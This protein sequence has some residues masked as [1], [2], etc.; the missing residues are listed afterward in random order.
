MQIL[1]A[2]LYE[3]NNRSPPTMPGWENQKT[4]EWSSG[5]RVAK[6]LLSWPRKCGHISAFWSDFK[7]WDGAF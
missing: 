1:P 7:V 4:G 2:T 3:K 5:E 6:I